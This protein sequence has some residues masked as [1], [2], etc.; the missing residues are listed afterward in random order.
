MTAFAQL[1]CTG[2]AC[3]TSRPASRYNN[4][5]GKLVSHGLPPA[6]SV[7]LDAGRCRNEKALDW[8]SP[9]AALNPSGS[10]PRSQDAVRSTKNWGWTMTQYRL[11][12]GL[13]DHRSVPVRADVSVGAKLTAPRER[14]CG[15]DAHDMLDLREVSTLPSFIHISRSASCDDQYHVSLSI[16]LA[17]RYRKAIY[18]VRYRPVYVDFARL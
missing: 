18:V 2:K 4:S 10:S 1:T 15:E 9:L 13:D 14:R 7:A 11:R 17:G 3:A 8:R 5:I 16:A 12:P 6:A